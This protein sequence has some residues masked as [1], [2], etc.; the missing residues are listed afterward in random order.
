MNHHVHQFGELAQDIIEILKFPA[1]Q[2]RIVRV[3][4]EVSDTKSYPIEDDTA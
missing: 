4:K 1:H 2:A 3:Y